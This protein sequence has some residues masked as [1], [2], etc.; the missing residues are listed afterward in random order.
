M[1]SEVRDLQQRIREDLT[2]AISGSV[3]V[4]PLD[5]MLYA[6]D[7]SLYQASPA[8]VAYP[9]GHDDVATLIRYAAEN[10]LSVTCRG[11]GSG[12]AG[13]CIGDGIIVDFSRLMRRI[14][15][16]DIER[17]TV[18]VQAG[19]VR[20][21]L[22]RRLRQ[23][24]LYFAPDPA[25]APVTTIGSMAAV[26]A[27]GSHRLRFG[28]TRS[29]I[30]SIRGATG[31][32][33]GFTATA[34][35]F[36]FDP[37]AESDDEPPRHEA[38][39]R[40]LLRREAAGITAAFEGRPD[41][42]AGY[43]LDGVLADDA[44]IDATRLLVGSEGTLA[45]FTELE[46]ALVPLACGRQAMMI[47]FAKVEDAVEAAL[48][49]REIR[50]D[51]CDLL[52]RRLLGVVGDLAPQYARLIAPSAE[53]G[54]LIDV[55]GDDAT[56]VADRTNAI[57]SRIRDV[58][59]DARFVAE[60]ATLEEASE[61]WQLP[62]RVLTQ[63]T[64]LSGDIRPLPIVEDVLIPPERMIEFLP[65]ARRVFQRYDTTAS[66][67]SHV[68]T[69][70]IHLRPLLPMPTTAK[71]RSQ[72][73]AIARDLYEVVFA[74]GGTISGEHGDG[75]SRTAFLRSRFRRLYPVFR[76]IKQI[77]DPGRVL[78]PDIIVSDDPHL[79]IRNLRSDPRLAASEQPDATDDTAEFGLLP[80]L[81]WPIT[82]Q[83][84]AFALEAD[85]CTGCGDCRRLDLGTR[86]CPVLSLEPIEDNAPRSKANAVRGLLDGTVRDEVWSSP[87]MAD[88]AERCF[89]CKQCVLDCPT[90]VDVP[91]L[92]IEAKAA[93]YGRAGLSRAN[94][95]LSRA[96]S[97]G[98]LAGPAAPI[99]NAGLSNG[100][101]RW[102]LE[103]A[104]GLAKQRKLPRFARRS[105][106]GHLRSDVLE[107][108]GEAADGV[109]R[110]AVYFVDHYA[111]F[112]DVELAT[113]AVAILR[114]NGVR[115]HVPRG[116]EP[117][118]MAMISAG[119]L[120]AA[121]ELAEANLALLGPLAG[122]G[123]PIVCTEPAAAIALRDDYPRLLTHPDAAAVAAKATEIGSYLAHLSAAGALRTDFRPV[124]G[125]LF[126]HTPCHIKVV[127]PD[128]PLLRLLRSVPGLRI[129][130]E[131][132]G[133]SGMA[134]A[135]GLSRRHYGD[136]V[137]IG[138]QLINETRRMPEPAGLTECS[139][140]KIQME[141]G[142]TKPT[143]HPVKL[144]AAAYGLLGDFNLAGRVSRRRG[145]LVVSE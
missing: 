49:I 87:Q 117:S 136:S 122:E 22:N 137:R 111:N 5:R 72:I 102:A 124:E 23:H 74:M 88:L 113:A 11:S 139:G 25:N 106:L 126:Y 129:R 62:R 138:R 99:L 35:G 128:R 69:G 89:N 18:R 1:P 21:Q 123:Y 8:A 39:L 4:E 58:R 53:C 142:T 95:F 86:M 6:C 48:A 47:L 59:P 133:C 76:D 45:A 92:M 101:I 63:L 141:Q 140:C 114:H 94:W 116:Q 77:F 66:F 26:D 15:E 105:F 7:A 110:T 17:R 84:S 79:T 91:H 9:A 31:E 78:S 67:Q 3:R 144:L 121:R 50:P 93:A 68:L 143:L 44:T 40:S 46:L 70:Q 145:R 37:A 119:D 115:V 10:G 135:Y 33:L 125:E 73:E 52:D 38:R 36:A 90:H 34:E 83:G 42:A 96:H 32:G 30:K 14:G 82:K 118:G 85:R 61:L 24:G 104:I 2:A 81:V 43:R 56:E 65:Q 75:R 132:R 134:G 109:R 28:S 20:D 112:H 130:D 57:R 71:D 107:P 108:T 97:F 80:Q 13:G 19:V 27:A 131:E 103:K 51:A 29:H 98:Q 54:L 60:A 55:I 12:V 41:A 100:P 127:S 16:I 120:D 64:R